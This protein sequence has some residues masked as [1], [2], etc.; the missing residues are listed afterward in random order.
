MSKIKLIHGV[1]VDDTQALRKEYRLDGETIELT[2]SAEDY[3]EF[4][5]QAVRLLPEPVF[6]FLE[7][8]R[9]DDDEGYD[10]YYLDNCTIPVAEA[11]LDRYGGILFSDGVIR[12]GFGSHSG[13]SEIYMREYQLLSVYSR[14][15][16]GFC[17]IAQE[18]GYLRNDDCVSI[19][20]ILS[21]NNRGMRE[22]VESDD[23]GYMNIVENLAEVGM[24]KA[25]R[26]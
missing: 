3:K 23:E 15:I 19:W 10:T 21:E 4:F 13:G 14:Y 7:I 22:S 8:P 26:E 12:F 25:D 5:K 16:D 11:I 2:L 1:S 20:D 6:F 9:E 17:E 24:Y 18:L